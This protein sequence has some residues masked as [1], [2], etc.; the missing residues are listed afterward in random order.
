MQVFFSKPSYGSGKLQYARTA[1]V[2]LIL[3]QLACIFL[4]NNVFFQLFKKPNFLKKALTC[5]KFLQ[6]SCVQTSLIIYFTTNMTLK[7][8]P[9]KEFLKR[10]W[11]C[12]LQ[13]VS[14]K[15][16]YQAVFFTHFCCMVFNAALLLHSRDLYCLPCLPI[17]K[18]TQ[19]IVEPTFNAS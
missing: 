15:N 14:K 6:R 8:L 4:Q 7:S 3:K 5:K 17:C 11:H 16:R 19:K 18:K 9:M 1:L 10:S 13:F 12:V 2:E